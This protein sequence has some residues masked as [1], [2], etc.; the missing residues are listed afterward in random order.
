MLGASRNLPT[1]PPERLGC[2]R[3]RRFPAQ[4]LFLTEGLLGF[5]HGFQTHTQH[6]PAQS[7][8]SFQ[9]AE[10]KGCSSVFLWEKTTGT[11]LSLK[12]PRRFRL[13]LREHKKS[14]CR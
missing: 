10:T 6:I 1:A 3:R 9:A 13:S 14:S 12:I 11:K 8:A 4:A 7:P 5:I 2:G